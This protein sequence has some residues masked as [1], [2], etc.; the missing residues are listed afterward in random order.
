[1][2][3]TQPHLAYQQIMYEG[4]PESCRTLTSSELNT[5]QGQATTV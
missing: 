5:L 4:K 2:D 3:E 1:M